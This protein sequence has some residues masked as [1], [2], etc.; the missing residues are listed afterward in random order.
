[1]PLK[2][3]IFLAFL[4]FFVFAAKAQAATSTID[5]TNKYA[6]GENIGWLN[7]G[8]PEGNVQ[9]GD[10]ALT[11]YIW[12]ENTGWVSLNCSNTSS[13][14]SVNYGVTNDGSGNLSGYAYGENVGWISFN[15]LNTSSCGTVSYG[16]T[17]TSGD[18]SGYAYG[19]NTGWIS[20][21]CLNTSSC[22]TVSYKT[23]LASS[24]GS[25][26]QATSSNSAGGGGG[27]QA[28][29]PSLPYPTPMFPSGPPPKFFPPAGT[30]HAQVAQPGKKQE[31]VFNFILP[32]GVT[33]EIKLIY[34]LTVSVVEQEVS[35]AINLVE[36]VWNIVRSFFRPMSLSAPVASQPTP[37]LP[38][39]N[40][41]GIILEAPGIPELFP[42][43]PPVPA[44]IPPPIPPPQNPQGANSSDSLQ[45]II[46]MLG[47]SY[48]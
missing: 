45:N 38:G 30:A 33:D 12:T 19:E 41:S 47:T 13:C 48:P 22:G 34:K 40:K 21:N 1:M 26:N 11:G 17:I 31:A 25:N 44:P 35:S 14:G 2:K 9:V 37:P 15:C 43:Q 10:T 5:T 8:T 24:G 3:V 46:N 29:L 28:E 7:L 18:F 32:S 16:V 4:I 36:R 6:Y 27:G 23:S 39:S 20:F 42:S